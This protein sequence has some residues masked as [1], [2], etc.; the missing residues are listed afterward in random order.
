MIAFTHSKHFPPGVDPLKASE[1]TGHWKLSEGEVGAPLDLRG[2][3][4]RGVGFQP[5][6]A[7]DT[8]FIQTSSNSLRDCAALIECSADGE[9][10]REFAVVNAENPHAHPPADE[11]WIRAHGLHG[12]VKVDLTAR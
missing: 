6:H 9:N 5:W 7:P 2:F 3:R 12:V 10:W 1:I 4:F 11:P 8:S